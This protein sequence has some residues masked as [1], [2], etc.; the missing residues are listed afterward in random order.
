MLAVFYAPRY[1]IHLTSF[2]TLS[3][4]SPTNAV[5]FASG[6]LKVTEM[7]KTGAMLNLTGILILNLTIASFGT[8]YFK[9]NDRDFVNWANFTS[10][11]GFNQT[12]I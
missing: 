4:S 5:A 9:L 6:R 12:N 3:A 2:S 10:C 7:M 11:P 8:F 1:K